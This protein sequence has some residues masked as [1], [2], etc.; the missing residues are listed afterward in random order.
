MAITLTDELEELINEKVKSGA[1]KSADEVII[2][3]LRLLEAQEKGMAAL[4]REIMCGVEDIEQGRF[5]A[6]GTDAELEAFSDEIIKQG[7][8]KQNASGKP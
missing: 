3:S 7:L 6:C 8:E 4:R 5:R 2:A 1:Y